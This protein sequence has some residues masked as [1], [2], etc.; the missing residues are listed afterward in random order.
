VYIATTDSVGHVSRVEQLVNG[1]GNS[2][3][4][5][6]ATR[7]ALPAGSTLYLFVLND[8][9]ISNTS[10]HVVQFLPNKLLKVL[11]HASAASA[12]G[13][14]GVVFAAPTGGTLAGA[15]IGEFT[16]KAF[17]GTLESG[18]AVLRVNVLE[19]GGSALTTSDLP[20][21]IVRNTTHTTGIVQASIIEE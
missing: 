3:I 6:T 14:N 9:G 15:E 12:T 13:V 19:F 21:V 11:V 5:I 2:S 18:Q 16:N 1:W 4:N 7:G 17:E 10:G 20:V 8:S